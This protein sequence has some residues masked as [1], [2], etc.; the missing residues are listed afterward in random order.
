MNDFAFEF[1]EAGLL[2]VVW[3]AERPDLIPVQGKIAAKQP[4]DDKGKKWRGIRVRGQFKRGAR[5]GIVRIALEIFCNWN[6]YAADIG[7]PE[8][9]G[10]D[11]KSCSSRACRVRAAVRR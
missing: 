8:L 11:P 4:F 7:I 6:Q 5:G 9:L 2:R 3:K 1:I 10:P